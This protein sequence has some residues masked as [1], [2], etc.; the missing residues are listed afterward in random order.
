VSINLVALPV[1]AGFPQAGT[2]GGMT[3][4]PRSGRRPAA[5]AGPGWPAGF[6]PAGGVPLA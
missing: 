2:R 1:M 6:I 5:G 3:G 4:K